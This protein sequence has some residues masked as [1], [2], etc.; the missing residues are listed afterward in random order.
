[1]DFTDYNIVQD[2]KLGIL[3]GEVSK[4]VLDLELEELRRK[5]VGLS[6]E[7]INYSQARINFKKTDLKYLY[8]LAK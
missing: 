1:M 7:I 6:W 3:L 4:I 2:E 8:I 5:D